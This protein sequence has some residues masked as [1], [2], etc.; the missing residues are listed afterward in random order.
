MEW[1]I[2]RWEI[3]SV[4]VTT[5]HVSKINRNSI[6]SLYLSPC[7]YLTWDSEQLLTDLRKIL[8]HTNLHSLSLYLLPAHMVQLDN[9]QIMCVNHNKLHKK[10]VWIV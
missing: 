1:G 6:F 2:W 3:V 10:I 7:V 4:N 8:E 5:S 9:K